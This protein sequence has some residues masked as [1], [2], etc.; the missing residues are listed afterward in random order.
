MSAVRVR[1]SHPH[2]AHTTTSR[3][4]NRL[5]ELRRQT[6]QRRGIGAF[7]ERK[8]PGLRPVLIEEACERLNGSIAAA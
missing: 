4:D 2:F 1:G 6:R 5:T 3:L 7:V 8:L